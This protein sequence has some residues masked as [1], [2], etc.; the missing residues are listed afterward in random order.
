[1][2]EPKAESSAWPD[3]GLVAELAPELAAGVQAF[4][5]GRVA[6][7]FGLGSDEAVAAVIGR[8]DGLQ[9]AL[10]TRGIVRLCS[11]SQVHGADVVPH[12]GSWRGWLR[13][14]GVDGHF[15]TTRG[16]AL[17]VTV[18]DCTPVFI[19]HPAGAVAALHAGWRGTAAGI[20][21]VGLRMFEAAGFPAD[22]CS[23][24]LGPAI[25]GSCYEVGP[26]VLTA[27]FGVPAASKGLLDVRAVLAN[28]A[29]ELGVLRLT[30]SSRC[31]RC[32]NAHFFSHRA[33][34]AGRQLG[35]ITLE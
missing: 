26:E 14:R 10:L 28:Q 29:A 9:A 8:W 4:T 35:V 27:M 5:T 23:V 15:T 20:L 13:L 22:E 24:H 21:P 16:T 18:A 19:A 7:S 34:D 25:C 30:T 3:A 2:V 12:D 32:D 1:M 11:A 33:G 17:A 6:G 31:T